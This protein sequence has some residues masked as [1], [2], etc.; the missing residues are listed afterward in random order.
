MWVE[1]EEEVER[2]VKSWG[3]V[4]QFMNHRP[5]C[6]RIH[7]RDH[8]LTLLCLCFLLH[9]CPF[10]PPISSPNF[11]HD[12]RINSEVSMY[13]KDEETQKAR[14]FEKKKKM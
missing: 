12:A 4:E 7:P 8:R 5:R 13:N 3:G 10:L 9:D 14:D 2:G 11:C 1:D 6:L